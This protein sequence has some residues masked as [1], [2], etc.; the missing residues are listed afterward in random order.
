MGYGLDFFSCILAVWVKKKKKK[1]G[2]RSIVDKVGRDFRLM[3]WE[4]RSLVWIDFL[5]F[6]PEILC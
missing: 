6:L 4:E 2:L 1:F 5:D 3:Q